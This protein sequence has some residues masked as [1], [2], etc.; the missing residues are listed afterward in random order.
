MF[1]VKHAR[2]F[3]GRFERPISSF[4]L[5]FGF[6]FDALTLRRVDTLWENIWVFGHLIIVGVFIALVHIKENKG[7]DE[8]D[9]T[10]PHFWYVN[11]LQFFFGGILSTYLVFYFRSTDIL[12]TWPFIFI[13]A[14]AFIANE[15]LKRHYVRLSFQISLFFLSVYSFA[16]FLVPVA[17]HKIGPWIFLLSG[18][19]SLVFI[20]LFI[21]VLFLFIKDKFTKSKNTIFLLIGGIFVLVNVLYFTNLIPPIPLSLK[22]AGMYHLIQRNAD[23][24]YTMEH[25]NLGIAGYFQLYQNFKEVP[26]KPIYAYS[27]VFSP[28]NLNV[29]VIHEWQYY[30][31][32][33]K[34]WITETK[35]ELPV[36]GGRDGGFRTYSVRYNLSVGKWRV[37]VETS[38]GQ[39]IGRLRFNIVLVD[40]EPALVIDV[41][42]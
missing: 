15:S 2:N 22:D 16:I 18:L 34:K 24:N 37:N 8:N 31:E 7:G 33:S 13:L 23:G 41:K 21:Y 12:A 42:Q 14:I 30:D 5:I 3:Y 39:L 26:G 29:T 11:I 40:T 27:A 19:L 35:I 28:S 1:I 10:K 32:L 25:E 9:P 17:I 4:S 38:Q 36:I 6:V 20:A